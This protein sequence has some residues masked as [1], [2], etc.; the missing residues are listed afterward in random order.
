MSPAPMKRRRAERSLPS[1]LLVEDDPEMRELVR[2]VLRQRCNVLMAS[3]ADEARA[4]L[5]A[6]RGDV[7]MI[8]LD[9]ALS[10]AEDGLT[11]TRELRGSDAFR[12]IPIVAETAYVDDA[13][14]L[15]ALSAGCD[16]FL[17]K[18]FY[19][20]DLRSVVDRYI[21]RESRS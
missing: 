9:L 2:L 11:L 7:R 10:G 12:T 17:A 5:T 21:E 4:Q 8:L 3:S 18:P 14:R 19:A 20:K 6:H 15:A 13:S 16:D 1:V